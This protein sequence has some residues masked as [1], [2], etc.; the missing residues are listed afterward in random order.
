M[1]VK[2]LDP[3]VASGA[4]SK[5][6]VDVE[7]ESWFLLFEEPEFELPPFSIWFFLHCG[8]M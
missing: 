2:E 8:F 5:A 6:D 3:A 4:D 1:D 7:L